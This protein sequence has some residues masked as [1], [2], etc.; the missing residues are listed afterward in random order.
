M[1]LTREGFKPIMMRFKLEFRSKHFSVKEEVC[2]KVHQTVILCLGYLSTCNIS[3]QND[4]FHIF[5]V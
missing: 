5:R 2:I 4:H 3:F 1:K